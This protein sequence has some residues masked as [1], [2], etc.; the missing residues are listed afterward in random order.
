MASSNVKT[1]KKK[2]KEAE[3]G[4]IYILDDSSS[5]QR[6]GRSGAKF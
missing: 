1:E 4:Q 2:T 5:T 6:D 3:S